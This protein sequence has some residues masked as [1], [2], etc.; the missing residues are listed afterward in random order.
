MKISAVDARGK[1]GLKLDFTG[2]VGF[3]R[4]TALVNLLRAEQICNEIRFALVVII[5]TFFSRNLK[6]LRKLYLLYM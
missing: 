3:L 4:R 1:H 2:S 5:L 6:R